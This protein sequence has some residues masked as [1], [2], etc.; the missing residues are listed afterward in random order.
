MPVCRLE[1][2]D[3]TCCGSELQVAAGE[4]AAEQVEALSSQLSAVRRE[5]EA[6]ATAVEE[7]SR[8]R[9]IF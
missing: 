2:N 5:L 4:A 9:V 1:A 7:L 6:A 3:P 8:E